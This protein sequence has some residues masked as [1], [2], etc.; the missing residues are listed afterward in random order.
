MAEPPEGD[1][2]SGATRG[3]TARRWLARGLAGAFVGGG[4]VAPTLLEAG[5]AAA[6]V[7]YGVSAAAAAGFTLA[8]LYNRKK[9]HQR[10]ERA[11]RNWRHE[12]D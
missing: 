4:L 9:R 5:E 11:L 6:F 2:E 8:W 3:R 10:L 12:H 1:L 7:G